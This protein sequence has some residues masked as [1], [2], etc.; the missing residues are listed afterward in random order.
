MVMAEK[1]EVP[2]DTVEYSIERRDTEQI[3]FTIRKAVFSLKNRP[4]SP[5][6]F[7]QYVKDADQKMIYQIKTAYPKTGFAW[8]WIEDVGGTQ[9]VHF[10]SKGLMIVETKAL[11]PQDQL[12]AIVKMSGPDPKL[13]YT[14]LGD[15]TVLA[16]RYLEDPFS[17][18]LAMTQPYK[19]ATVIPKY[20]VINSNGDVIADFK[21]GPSKE[22]ARVI[23]NKKSIDPLLVLSLMIILGVPQY[24]TQ[25]QEMEYGRKI[26]GWPNPLLP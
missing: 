5:M 13:P 11:G 2:P 9:L 12:L 25:A 16:E 18:K 14:L 7:S 23:I 15:P 4:K 20:K 24:F 26:K 22:A 17:R 8:S 3:M 21:E 1:L 6:V 10:E 19:I